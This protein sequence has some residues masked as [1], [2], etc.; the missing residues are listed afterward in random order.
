LRKCGTRWNADT[1]GRSFVFRLVEEKIQ[2]PAFGI[3]THP[4]IPSIGHFRLQ[5]FGQTQEFIFLE[6]LDR[7]LD[8]FNRAHESERFIKLPIRKPAAA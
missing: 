1:L 3:L 4:A 5:L 2:F 7:S 6:I 8:V